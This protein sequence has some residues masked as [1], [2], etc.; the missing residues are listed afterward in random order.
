M[1]QMPISVES[2]E[3]RVESQNPVRTLSHRQS[4]GVS[5]STCVLAA[6][7][8]I[9]SQAAAGRIPGR[10]QAQREQVQ[11]PAGDFEMGN[12]PG[13]GGAPDEAPAHRPRLS[14]F[15]IDKLEVTNREYRE[16]VKHGLCTTPGDTSSKTRK[17]YYEDPRFDD[18]PI[19][20]VDWFQADAYCRW[21]GGRLPTEAE[22]EKTARGDKDRRQFPW[23][24]RK[25]DCSLANFG[26]PDGCGGDTDRVGARPEGKSPYGALDMAGNVWEWVSDWYDPSYYKRS[27]AADPRGPE[28][29]SFKVMRGGCFDTAPDGL[30]VSCRNRDFPS[31]RRVN[32]GF[33]CARPRNLPKVE[34]VGEGAKRRGRE[35]PEERSDEGLR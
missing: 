34:G 20:N 9:A 19:V 15:A 26:G 25:P 5:V 32:V 3:S 22:W 14:P 16:C 2:Q 17:G 21:T 23:G 31:S 29:G 30:R 28:W 1:G 24:D 7:S 4:A 11:V 35:I 10:R 27:T 18:H 8:L 6:L 13:K 33:R 12:D